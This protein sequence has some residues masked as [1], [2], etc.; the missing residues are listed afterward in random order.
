METSMNSKLDTIFK[1][2][3]LNKLGKIAYIDSLQSTTTKHF[4]YKNILV[5]INL[6]DEFSSCKLEEY[7]C[8]VFPMGIDEIYL[9]RFK[10]KIY[11]YLQNGGFI[12]S[13]MSNFMQIL[14]FS[15]GYIQSDLE[16]KDREVR[17]AK[18][19]VANK[20]FKGVREYDINFR[21]GVKGF[22]NRGYFDLKEFKTKPINILEDNEGKCV[23]Y[24]D[25]D[26]TNGVI[27]SSANADLLSFGLFDNNTARAI[28]LNLLS[29][30]EA[31]LTLAKARLKTK[32]L[33]PYTKN[34]PSF[35]D[36][37][38]KKKQSLKSAIIT[39]GSHFNAFFFS[40]KNKKYESF[41]DKK[42]Y[43]L[44]ILEYDFK[45]FDFIAL[46]SRLNSCI[47]NKHKDKFLEYLQNGGS[48]ISFGEIKGDYLP[49]V[50]WKDYPVNFW[51]W[52]IKDSDMPLY[53][54]E[55]EQ[56]V[57]KTS[58]GLFSKISVEDAKWHAHGAFYPPKNSQK[59]L[60]NE[61]DEAIIYKD[62]SFKGNLY[63]TSLDPDFHL[64]QGFM[65]KTEKFFDSFME[66]VKEDI[67][68][69]EVV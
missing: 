47:L 31:E 9:S 37:P 2:E 24:L 59:I 49:N 13:F 66:W 27:L 6:Y 56:K 57:S 52:L 33:F 5:N 11:A 10:D 58:S 8:V 68:A 63:I 1:H 18:N 48:I 34:P 64:G 26:S 35:L 51:W 19:D 17:I 40:N 41:F 25:R 54:L 30:L 36:I 20:I 42:I 39:G 14:P 4:F 38:C 44:D 46:S 22:F 67:L 15:S 62:L 55:G 32:T 23:A 65:P 45:E 12:F 21:R 69:K 61:I 53:A 29:F 43:L 16:I 60:V 28:G 3:S 7:L 50:I